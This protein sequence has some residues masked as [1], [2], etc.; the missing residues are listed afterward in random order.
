MIKINFFIGF[1]AL[2]HLLGVSQPKCIDSFE[3]RSLY[4]TRFKY[5]LSS[6]PVPIIGHD[7][8][9]FYNASW[10]IIKKNKSNNIEWVRSS[11]HRL[12]VQQP[13]ADNAT[14]G[15]FANE[16][17]GIPGGVRGIF[18]LSSSGSVL[19]SRRIEVSMPEFNNRGYFANL[20]K[21]NQEDIVLCNA[22][23]DKI[24]V[25]IFNSDASIVKLSKNFKATFSQGETFL[26]SRV[27]VASNAIYI[28]AITQCY[29]LLP[30]QL[31]RCNLLLIKLN[32]ETGA[33]ERVAYF[34]PND[35]IINPRLILQGVLSSSINAVMINNSSLLISG[36]K[37]TY[38]PFTNRFYTIKLDTTF[39]VVKHTIYQAPASHSYSTPDGLTVPSI[40]KNG[41]S[42]FAAL[43]DS[44][45]PGFI[46][47][48]N[49]CYYFMTDSNLNVLSQKHLNIAQTGFNSK[50]YSLNAVPLLKWNN[51]AEIVL[52]TAG[53]EAD[54]LLHIVEIPSKLNE[55]PCLG[56]NNLF[57]TTDTP[58]IS[59]LTPPILTT[60]PSATLNISTYHLHLYNTSLE[61]SKFCV[62]KSIC[63]SINIKGNPKFCLP[64]DSTTFTAYKNS[65]CNRRL[66]WDIDST[67]IKIISQPTDSTIKVNFL[68]PYKGY[69]RASFEGCVLKDSLFIDVSSPKQPLSLGKDSM[70]CPGK[71][72]T[73]DA[74]AGFRTYQ[75]QNNSSNQTFTVTNPGL[76]FAEVTDSCGNIFRD[77]ILI[78]P[79]DV[80]FN[81]SYPGTICQYDTAFLPVHP[82]LYDFTWSPSGDGLF[83]NNRL[84]FFPLASTTFNVTATRLPGCLLTD[85]VLIEVEKCPI[86]IH[87]PNA[88][89]PNNDGNND[90]FRPIIS[91]PMLRYRFDIYNRYGQLIFS[92]TETGKGWDGTLRGAVQEA[93]VF[94]WT[95][96]YQFKAQPFRQK[97]GTVMLLR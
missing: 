21:G 37:Y 59:K 25:T 10:S 72:I 33:L 55:S 84:K 26:S 71:T 40:D 77:S 27:V 64:N 70:H 18:K 46:G 16:Q 96:T 32:Y 66:L 38:A 56:E 75:W 58:T 4:N 19:W 39:N 88:F 5:N 8:C 23:A 36:R 65:L 2:T 76:Y 87:I 67:A 93:G 63:D 95:C 78:K 45:S 48:S 79:M 14:I 81:P 15:T 47:T 3:N 34:H 90:L 57:I 86:Y 41:N 50:G 62:Q 73:L 91:G 7:S 28:F 61:E 60:I 17:L 35:E 13:T 85:T 24:G 80:G 69:I 54:S 51:N 42:L 29:E 52:H 49:E 44:V 43:K 53:S 30:I 9:V 22:R 89:S 31:S 82:K 11:D 6:L 83:Q 12:D 74:G 92:T 68:K 94:T 1:F 97:K 20:Q